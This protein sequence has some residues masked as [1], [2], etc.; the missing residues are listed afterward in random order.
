MRYPRELVVA[1]LFFSPSAAL[2]SSS[3]SVGPITCWTPDATIEMVDCSSQSTADG[4]AAGHC[5]IITTPD[6]KRTVTKVD[7][8]LKAWGGIH[9]IHKPVHSLRIK[10]DRGRFSCAFTPSEDYSV[11]DCMIGPASGSCTVLKTS[12]GSNRYFRA[13]ATA[14]PD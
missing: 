8:I 6:G 5:T 14:R 1:L 4:G 9:P 3:A 2:A 11:G 13:S 12:N 7:G 10:Y